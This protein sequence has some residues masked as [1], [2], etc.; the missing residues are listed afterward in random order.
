MVSSAFSKGPEKRIW[1]QL[2]KE[3]TYEQ[4]PESEIPGPILRILL[5]STFYGEIASE[6]RFFK[7]TSQN[8][9]PRHTYMLLPN[10]TMKYITIMS[11]GNWLFRREPSWKTIKLM[12][13]EE[14]ETRIKE[15]ILEYL[16]KEPQ[17][18]CFSGGILNTERLQ[19]I[20]IATEVFNW[21]ALKYE[22]VLDI[23]ARQLYNMFT[24][25]EVRRLEGDHWISSIKHELFLFI[26]G[27]VEGMNC[28]DRVYIN[29]EIKYRYPSRRRNR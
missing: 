2:Y 26:T 27:G 12:S 9:G 7:I 20:D 3:N 25:G 6:R 11:N 8:C 28:Y 5:S 14:V 4:V 23:T 24:R 16:S 17:S 29:R 13:P 19:G 1:D 18:I 21:T 22:E 10:D 15:I